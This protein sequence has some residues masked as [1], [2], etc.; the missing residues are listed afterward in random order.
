VV[1][2]CDILGRHPDFEC[3][4][5]LALRRSL[6]RVVLSVCSVLG[7]GDIG[8]Q[9]DKPHG[10]LLQ[11]AT[12]S[13]PFLNLKMRLIT[14]IVVQN[15][16]SKHSSRNARADPTPVTNTSGIGRQSLRRY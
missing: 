11:G 9:L 8:E 13:Q 10:G 2:R 7:V 16:R 4:L 5:G 14:A 1:C 6:E 15:R 3:F 12:R